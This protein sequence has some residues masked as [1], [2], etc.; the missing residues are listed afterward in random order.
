M[1]GEFRMVTGGQRQ[2]YDFIDLKEGT[3]FVIGT[4]MILG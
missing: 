1:I 4:H 2:V 3:F